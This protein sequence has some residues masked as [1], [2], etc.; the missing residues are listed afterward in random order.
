M[1]RSRLLMSRRPDWLQAPQNITRLFC[2]LRGEN[3]GSAQTSIY[4]VQPEAGTK[5]S[6]IS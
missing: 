5:A 4:K 6:H 2:S 3:V 1:S